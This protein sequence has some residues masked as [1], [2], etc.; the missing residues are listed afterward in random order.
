MQRHLGITCIL[1]AAAVRL[2]N[3]WA[4]F[5]ILR[6]ACCMTLIDWYLCRACKL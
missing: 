2:A 4:V 6:T 3:F 5:T 1:M